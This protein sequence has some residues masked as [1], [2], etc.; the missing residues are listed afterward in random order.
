MGFISETIQKPYTSI[1]ELYICIIPGYGCHLTATVTRV[2]QNCQG[3]RL[4]PAYAIVLNSIFNC[5]IH[6]LWYWLTIYSPVVGKCDRE[7]LQVG[8]FHVQKFE[9][10]NFK[11]DFQ[12]LT[13]Q[14]LNFQSN[15]PTKSDIL[16]ILDGLISI[17]WHG[18][19]SKI[20][21]V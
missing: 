15:S 8:K 9:L 21:L 1:S 20:R 13:F 7:N 14:L 18:Q 17:M 3:T 6:N 2:R 4:S 5:L 16:F 10:F 19:P 12:R 11:L